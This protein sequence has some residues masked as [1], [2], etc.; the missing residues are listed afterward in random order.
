MPRYRINEL[1]F[2]DNKLVQPGDEIDSDA[3][4]SPHWEPLDKPGEKARA[5]ADAAEAE[6][7]AELK[8]QE[9]ALQGAMQVVAAAGADS[10]V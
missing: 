1:S 5:A 3:T 6:R 4:P 10:L 7:V 2:I 8:K 9:A